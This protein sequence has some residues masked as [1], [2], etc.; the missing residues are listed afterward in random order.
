MKA[1]RGLPIKSYMCCYAYVISLAHLL[2]VN[3]LWR[4]RRVVS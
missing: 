1:S 4:N 3:S 2:S